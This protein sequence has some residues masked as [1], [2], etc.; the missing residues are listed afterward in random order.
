VHAGY[1]RWR[2]PLLEAGIVLHE[3]RPA[4]PTPRSGATAA[5]DRG[6]GDRSSGSGSGDAGA[7]AAAPAGSVGSRPS[8]GSLGA[9]GSRGPRR[10]GS[11][12]SSTSSLHAKTFSIDRSRVVIG[13]FNF[14][15]RSLDLNTELGF[16]IDSA[17]L[18]SAVDE[19]Y[20]RNVPLTAWQVTLTEA[21]ELQWTGQVDG[22][23]VRHDEEPDAGFWRRAGAAMIRLLPVDWML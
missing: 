1:A 10:A 4:A 6:K 22:E 15:P 12:G 21:G 14:D 16:V 9:G 13:S 18:A 3:Y 17:A 19:A 11:V 8:V 5:R 20:I 23:P 7:R 2:K